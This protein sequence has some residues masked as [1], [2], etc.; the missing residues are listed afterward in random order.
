[1]SSRACLGESEQVGA[2]GGEALEN[3]R[4]LGGEHAG[5]LE[6]R[7][8]GCDRVEGSAEREQTGGEVL[9]GLGE[10]RPGAVRSA[11]PQTFG[12]LR[13]LGDGLVGAVEVRHLLVVEV[14]PDEC[15][16]NVGQVLFGSGIGELAEDV[17][18]LGIVFQRFRKPAE[19]AEVKGVVAEGSG[20][21]GQVH[22][23]SAVSQAAE[24]S[25]G[26]SEFL[27]GLVV[28]AIA[29]QHDGAVVVHVGQCG[30]EAFA[31]GVDQPL[32]YVEGLTRQ[33]EPLIDAVQVVQEAAEVAQQAG[34]HIGELFGQQPV[35]RRR[36]FQ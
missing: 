7:R 31:I 11:G 23:G 30:F 29:A 14:E 20:E 26:D 15:V 8:G 19:L 9:H 33:G 4:L 27:F 13:G 34:E 32:S 6:R 22:L 21:L 24:D 10:L 2:L 3:L 5:G 1:V 12:D 18:R 17:Q 16:D 28:S 36:T 25:Y 35:D